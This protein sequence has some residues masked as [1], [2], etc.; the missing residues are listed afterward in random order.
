MWW[1]MITG[2][3]VPSSSAAAGQTKSSAKKRQK[4]RFII[5]PRKDVYKR[6]VAMVLGLCVV[7]ASA[8][9]AVENFTDDYQKVGA[10]Y[11]EAMGV[12]VGVCLL[13]TSRCV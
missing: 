3:R 2:S 4:T 5:S 11:Q 8:K 12:L 6:Q 1:Y 13:Y 7:G 10:A 9:D